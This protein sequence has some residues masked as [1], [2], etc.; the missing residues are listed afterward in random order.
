MNAI[1]LFLL[2][3]SQL[4]SSA[5]P[6]WVLDTCGVTE[7]GG[8]PQDT[9]NVCC[10]I[11]AAAGQTLLVPFAADDDDSGD[12]ITITA[13]S[14][15][16]LPLGAS[17]DS[18]TS[19]GARYSNRAVLRRLRFTP[20]KTHAGLSFTVRVRASDNSQAFVDK[21]VLISVASPSLPITGPVPEGGLHRVP[22]GCTTPLTV[23]VADPFYAA[24]L[25]LTSSL[26]PYATTS[27]LSASRLQVTFNPPPRSEGA[28]TRL[29]FTASDSLGIA[30]VAD[31]CFAV[32]V[33]RCSVCVGPRETLASVNRR[34]YGDDFW[35]RLWAL[36]P[37]AAGPDAPIS[38]P[39][40]N[41]LIGN[42]YDVAEGETVGSVAAK[43]GVGVEKLLAVNGDLPANAGARLRVGQEVCVLAC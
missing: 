42:V 4:V 40:R 25:S 38:D 12:A 21:C 11:S 3:T 15:P 34:I 7:V 6:Y 41:V 28:V 13:S 19:A 30:S 22:V 2:L 37:A 17:L 36:N 32:V 39:G 8:R 10:S 23:S 29:C 1:V 20:S 24:S 31:W 33:S 27:Q 5:P 9:P 35:Q 26:P 16:G 43:F 14:D 18:P